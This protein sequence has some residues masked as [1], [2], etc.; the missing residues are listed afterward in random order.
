MEVQ[1]NKW[2][3]LEVRNDLASGEWCTLAFSEVGTE[4]EAIAAMDNRN[5]YHRVHG[6]KGQRTRVVEVVEERRVVAGPKREIPPA[7]LCT[8]CGKRTLP[9]ACKM[10]A[11]YTQEFER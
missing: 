5:E 1:T 9:C 10:L 2:Y 6:I 11:P 3:A 7:R 8:E 4:P